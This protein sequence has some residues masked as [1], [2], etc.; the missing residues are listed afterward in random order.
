MTDQ[1]NEYSKAERVVS[2]LRKLHNRISRNAVLGPVF[3]LLALLCF[4]SVCITILESILYL[5]AWSKSAG[6]LIV[7]GFSLFLYRNLSNS[8]SRVP[9]QDFH[10]TFCKQSGLEEIGNAIDLFLSSGAKRTPFQNLA[11]HRNLEA[12][13]PQI[14]ENKQID[15]Y[16]RNPDRSRFLA[17]SILLGVSLLLLGSISLSYPDATLRT[18]TFWKSTEK[19]NPYQFTVLPGDQTI[20]Y[21]SGFTPSV[22]YSKG[23]LP[24]QVIL[25]LKTDIENEFR[26]RPMNP[27]GNGTFSA[28]E[29]ELTGD[30]AYFIEM[31]GFRTQEYRI[32]VRHLPRFES[33]TAEITPP[34]Y[35]GLEITE[36]N[37][38]FA[39][40]RAYGGS[41][42]VLTG[43]LNKPVDDIRVRQSNIDQPMEVKDPDSFS[44]EYIFTVEENDTIS[45]EMA[46]RDGLSNR[47]PFRFTVEMIQDEYPTITILEPEQMVRHPDP[48][49]LEILY[50]ADDDFGLTGAELEYELKRAFTSEPLTGST[51]LETPIRGGLGQ[52][53]WDLSPLEL[54]PRDRLDVSILIRDNDGWNGY[55][56]TRSRIITLEVPSISAWMEEFEQRERSVEETMESVSEQYREMEEEYNE[57]RNRLQENPEP[58]WEEQQ[59]LDDVARQQENVE[60]SI[61]RLQEQ[62]EEIRNEMDENSMISDETRNAYR[63]LQS[64]MDELDDPELREA[65]EELQNVLSNLNPQE[66]Q[67]ALEQFEFN[68]SVFRERVERTVELFKTLKMN[69]DLDKL[70]KQ[71]EELGNR[72]ESTTDGTRPTEEIMDEQK[73]VREDTGHLDRQLENLNR[74]PPQRSASRLEELQRESRQELHDIRQ[75][76]EELIEESEQNPDEDRPERTERREQL[77]EQFRERAETLRNAQQQMNGQQL[78]INLLAMQRSLYTLIELSESQEEVAVSSG[79]TATRSQGFV[80]LARRQNNINIQ[81][82]QVSDTLAQIASEI[83]SLSGTINRKKAEVEQTLGRARDQ[84]TERDQRMSVI[85]SR[86]SLGGINDLASM[87]ATAIDQLMDQQ[88]GAGG[89]MSMQQ[90]LEEMQQMSGDQQELNR[91]LQEL[92]ND[93]QGERLTQEQSNRLE[94]LTQQQNEI[95]RKL[96]ELQRDGALRE[97]DGSLSEIQR[98]LEEMED[99]VND[100]RGGMT[101]PIM[102]RRQ[103]NILSRMLDAEE[104]LQERGE[105]EDEYR[106]RSATPYQRITPPNVTLEELRQEIRTRLHDPAFTRFRDEYQLLIERYFDLLREADPDL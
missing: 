60:D 42:V 4:G 29:L 52:H 17:G 40:I 35:T 91:Q 14:W 61:S 16:K 71:Y 50:R 87:I 23:H 8:A 2:D 93:I 100:M 59:L 94:Q 83:P 46:D 97:G 56:R 26:R 36:Q 11:I 43:R 73:G 55:K 76:L 21:G 3:S 27:E 9:F 45:F 64:L 102:V 32:E 84:M 98:M 30:G 49:E 74:N 57:F 101:D 99:A 28:G 38:P 10:R 48:A 6:W 106:G 12:F 82:R 92:I 86:E 79:E 104:S 95:R 85:A 90:M 20:E 66:L 77:A 81:F 68:E 72:M 105:E 47:N 13:Q 88:N 65:L 58:G 103:Q 5:P 78:E 51:V 7:A 89:S 54:R 31:D 67:Q 96:Q 15:F 37:Y 39:R 53:L 70:A 69:S 33:L 34:S 75:E 63:E 24:T 62:F 18:L 25:A 41:E 1:K 44:F 22:E 19:P 80:D